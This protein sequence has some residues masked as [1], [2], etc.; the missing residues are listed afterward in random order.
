MGDVYQATDTKLGRS[1]AI[2]F[3]P[4]AF[5]HERSVWRVLA[6]SNHSNISQFTAWKNQ[7]PSLS[8]YGTRFRTNAGRSHPSCDSYAQPHVTVLLS[9]KSVAN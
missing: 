5:S 9:T 3:L 7:R 8:R 1:V 6:S 2:K 4:E